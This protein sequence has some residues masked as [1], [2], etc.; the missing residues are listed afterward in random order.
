[1]ICASESSARGHWD[2]RWASR[3]CGRPQ[4]LHHR[5]LGFHR[6]FRAPA[7]QHTCH[8]PPANDGRRCALRHPDRAVR[9]AVQLGILGAGGIAWIPD[10]PIQKQIDGPPFYADANSTVALS[11]PP[12][13]GGFVRESAARGAGASCSRHDTR[14][15]P[16][17]RARNVA[18]RLRLA[19][20]PRTVGRGLSVGQAAETQIG[21]GLSLPWRSGDRRRRRVPLP[22]R[23]TRSGADTIT[24]ER[25]RRGS[26]DGRANCRPAAGDRSPTFVTGACWAAPRRSGLHRTG[27]SSSE[28]SLL[29]SP[30]R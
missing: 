9:R 23:T 13:A 2:S 17:Q 20:V 26:D 28:I 25:P 8:S 7:S 19:A 4:Q 11:S 6:M 27:A 30:S 22:H 10:S 16:D 18:H 14:R 15:C 1:M 24:A 21:R 3:S 29:K 5:S 12:A